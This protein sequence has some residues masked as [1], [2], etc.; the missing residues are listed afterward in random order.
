MWQAFTANADAQQLLEVLDGKDKEGKEVDTEEE[1]DSEINS[2]DEEDFSKMSDDE[3]IEDDE[4][5]MEDEQDSSGKKDSEQSAE[6]VIG[7]DKQ[8]PEQHPATKVLAEK[9]TE[10]TTV[11]HS[12][13][14]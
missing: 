11:D 14:K 13:S 3:E 10:E 2:E 12:T 7:A 1:D 9:T 5:D 6:V 4:E 8:P